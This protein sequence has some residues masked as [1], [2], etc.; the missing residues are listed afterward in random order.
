MSFAKVLPPSGPWISRTSFGSA[1]LACRWMFSPT[2]VLNVC[3][4]RNDSGSLSS[5]FTGSVTIRGKLDQR[6]RNLAGIPGAKCSTSSIL[7]RS[8]GG[9]CEHILSPEARQGHR[10]GRKDTAPLAGWRVGANRGGGEAGQSVRLDTGRVDSQRCTGGAA[11]RRRVSGI[12]FRW[13]VEIP[14]ADMANPRVQ[15]FV[16][17]LA[18]AIGAVSPIILLA[19]SQGSLL[20]TVEMS[21]KDTLELILHFGAGFLDSLA[22][23]QI[24]IPIKVDKNNPFA[25]DVLRLAE[26]FPIKL[27]KLHFAPGDGSLVLERKAR[28]WPNQ[29][30]QS[31]A[32]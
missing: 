6:T 23:S 27:K 24:K 1:W 11:Q 7:R 16:K 20:L 15:D 4:A 32:G 22:I 8:S 5:I 9:C 28:S 2:I 19:V 14:E 29:Q 13:E 21:E 12:V 10:S 25:V 30:S 31:G 18:A 17:R 3:Q 26:Q